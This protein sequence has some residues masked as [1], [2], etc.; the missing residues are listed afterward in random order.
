MKQL[1]IFCAV[2]FIFIQTGVMAEPPSEELLE[3]YIGFG[4][5][6]FDYAGRIYSG[7]L[8]TCC[9]DT[10]KIMMDGGVANF[11]TEN[12]KEIRN[13]WNKIIFSNTLQTNNSVKKENDKIVD[14]RSFT[15]KE[16]PYLPCL[17]FTIGGGY[18]AFDSFDKAKDYDDAAEALNE[19][20]AELSSVYSNS[21]LTALLR[22]K[23]NKYK[24]KSEDKMVLGV[25]STT[26]AGLS[27]ILSISPVEREIPL[28]INKDDF[29]TTIT[30][31]WAIR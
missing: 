13:R 20:I 9:D 6:V 7:I 31:A 11:E 12:I 24:K 5:M 21:E 26:V 17:I 27:F 16:Y 14:K 22:V 18:L 29:G 2:L 23:M 10:T 19:L 30:F 1:C 15:V 4:V 3:H 25:I 8:I 28:T